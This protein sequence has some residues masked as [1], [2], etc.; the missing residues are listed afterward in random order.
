[1]NDEENTERNSKE[2]LD[3]KIKVDLEMHIVRARGN[4]A[5]ARGSVVSEC[6]LEILQSEHVSG[7]LVDT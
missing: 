7:G 6:D 2:T 1:V 4:T 5:T 3:S